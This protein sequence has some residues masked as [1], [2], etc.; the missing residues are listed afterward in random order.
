MPPLEVYTDKPA[1]NPE[2]DEE[3]PSLEEILEELA[4]SSPVHGRRQRE[5]MALLEKPKYVFISPL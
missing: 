5:L 3:D 2:E 1:S 4:K